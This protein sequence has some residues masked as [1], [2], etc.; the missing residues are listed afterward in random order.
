[1]CVRFSYP[2]F[3]FYVEAFTSY[4]GTT[5]RTFT[6]CEIHF[7]VYTY[8]WKKRVMMFQK[9][10]FENIVWEVLIFERMSK[11]LL[12]FYLLVEN[13]KLSKIIFDFVLPFVTNEIISHIN[14][15]LMLSVQKSQ[16]YGIYLSVTQFI[17]KF[18]I[19]KKVL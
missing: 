7:H 6:Y 5:L 9:Y 19:K 1:M 12:T 11:Q 14:I 16:K 4:M 3:I 8:I 13:V 18:C 15:I 10:N 2:F 17:W